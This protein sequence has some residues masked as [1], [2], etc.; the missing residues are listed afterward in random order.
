MNAWSADRLQR[1]DSAMAGHVERGTVPGLVT[2]V[3]RRGETY[4]TAHGTTAVGG[5]E[6][7]RRDTIF[8]IASLTKPVTA[9]AALILIEECRLSLDDAVD[10]LLPELADRRVLVDPDGPLEKTVPAERSITVRDLLTFTMGIGITM[11]PSPL[12]DALFETGVHLGPDPSKRN[13]DDWMALLGSFPLIHQPGTAWNYDTGTVVLGIL[14]ERLTGQTLAEFMQ[15]RIFDPLRMTD[16]GFQ[17]RADKLYRLASSYVVDQGT[18]KLALH[19]DP[20]DSRFAPPPLLHSGSGGLLSTAEDYLAFSRM[21]L[22]MGRFSGGRILSRASV[23]LMTSDHLTP[24]LRAGNEIFF[25]SDTSWG[26]GVGIDIRRS[27]LATRPGRFGWVGGTGT[28]AYSDYSEDVT[29]ILLTQRHMDS[30]APVRMH[31]DFWNGTYQAIE[32]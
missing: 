9:V 22:D 6:P 18:G 26:L 28:A 31:A 8:R 23:T 27:N 30:P 1:L 14:I 15:E 2:L 20:A 3:S 16:T 32:D 11:T 25:G 17:A 5:T 4:V 19:D 24:Q 21:L 13:A 29:G 10:E 7:M 12:G